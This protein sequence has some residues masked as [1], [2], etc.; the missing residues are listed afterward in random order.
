MTAVLHVLDG[1]CDETQWHVLDILLARLADGHDPHTVCTIHPQAMRRAHQPEGGVIRR[2]EQR[3]WRAMNY[4]PRL[5]AAARECGAQIL[6]AWG[7]Q[8]AAVCSA[9]LPA[10]PLVVTLLDP[11]HARDSASR[12][13]SLPDWSA[14]IVGSQVARKQLVTAGV[15]PERV[16]VIRGPADFAAINKA[17]AAGLRARVVGESRPVVLMPGPPSRAG[18]QF[19]GLWAA[20]IVRQVIPSIRILMP[21]ESAESHRLRRFVEQIEMSDMLVVPDARW[22]WPQLVTCADVFLC[23]AHDEIATEPIALA[24]AAG[25][26]IVGTAVRSVAE[27]IAD[28]SN[29]FLCK[30]NDPRAL[31][32][33]L[34]T[35]LEDA[36]LARRVTEVARGQAYEVF[37]VR[38]FADNYAR[39]YENIL[40]GRP[41]GDAVHDT[42]YEPA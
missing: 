34:L 35:A 12:L 11:H 7:P 39:V 2:A 31:A 22:S 3:L 38:A 29:G 6:H 40:T 19:Y 10:T 27:L 33:R 30:P 42:A 21:Y 8:A 28:K 26:V 15:P 5:P 24:M 9:R 14:V 41:C 20:A 18:G 32:G 25:L 23:P 4:A 1:A 37:G 16:V 17:R 36:D 13:R